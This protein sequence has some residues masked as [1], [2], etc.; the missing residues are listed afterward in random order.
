MPSEGHK[1]TGRP[2]GRPRGIPASPQAKE[3][4]RRQMLA[5]WA[6]PVYRAKQTAILRKVSA[7]GTAA[8]LKVTTTPFWK[9][10]LR[11]LAK[12]DP[13]RLPPMSAEDRKFYIKLMRRYN[14]A[15]ALAL[16]FSP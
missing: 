14:R 16:V 7:A 3:R 4:A 5:K 10:R 11:A 8:S 9:G 12:R 6:D 13:R 2:R 1:A 15:Q